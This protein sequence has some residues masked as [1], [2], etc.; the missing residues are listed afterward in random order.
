MQKQVPEHRR[1]EASLPLSPVPVCSVCGVNSDYIRRA[2]QVTSIL[3]GKWKLQILCAMGHEAVRLGQLM[4][5]FPA[6]S[7]KSV[8]VNYHMIASIRTLKLI[9]RSCKLP[10]G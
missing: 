2:S 3:Q 5:R 7:E 8:V 6:A 4:R 9:T 10:G 1:D